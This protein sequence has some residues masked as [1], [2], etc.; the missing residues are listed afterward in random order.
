MKATRVRDPPKPGKCRYRVMYEKCSGFRTAEDFGKC[1][2]CNGFG[3]FFDSKTKKD[4]LCKD[5]EK[6][7]QSIEFVKRQLPLI[8]AGV[9]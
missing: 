6:N 2:D 5:Y 8:R 4:D 3:L 9:I 7:M 1:V